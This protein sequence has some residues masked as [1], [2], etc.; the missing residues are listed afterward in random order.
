MV[1]E[2]SS[3]LN[4]TPTEASI[5][6]RREVFRLVIKSGDVAVSALP[7]QKVPGSIS[8]SGAIFFFSNRLA[9]ESNQPPKHGSLGFP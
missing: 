6:S 4:T 1:Q 9:P 3:A 5:L 7:D 2:N 8:Y